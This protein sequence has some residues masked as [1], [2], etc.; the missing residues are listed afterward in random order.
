M[1]TKPG[2]GSAAEAEGFG[3]ADVDEGTG[4]TEAGVI[5][6][7]R[8]NAF[9]DEGVEAFGGGNCEVSQSCVDGDGCAAFSFSVKEECLRDVNI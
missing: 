6:G 4:V 8:G 3:L 1:P 7:W 9:V 5:G 2:T